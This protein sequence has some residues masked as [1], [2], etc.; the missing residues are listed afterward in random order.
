MTLKVLVDN[1]E[2]SHNTKQIDD[3]IRFPERLDVFAH[4]VRCIRTLGSCFWLGCNVPMKLAIEKVDSSKM[5][6]DFSVNFLTNI[7]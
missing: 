1:A 7:V 2:R 3:Q 5:P 4:T 6:L